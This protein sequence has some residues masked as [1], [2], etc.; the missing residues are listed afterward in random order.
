MEKVGFNYK[1]AM[2]ITFLMVISFS[3]IGPS[4]SSPTILKVEGPT[5]VDINTENTFN[6]SIIAENVKGLYGWELILT[7]SP[8]IVNC[9]SET[10]NYNIWGANNFLGPL[11][12]SPINNE[13]GTYWQG[14]TGKN[15]GVPQDGNFWLV[16]LTFQIVSSTTAPIM[17]TIKKAPGYD[18][19]CLLD[20]NGQEIP[21]QYQQYLIEIVPEF[22]EFFPLIFLFLT[23]SLVLITRKLMLKVLKV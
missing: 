5:E 14:L 17:F 6:I 22:S 16:N 12:T 18:N 15:P 7:W 10:L 1:Y 21:H 2:L 11:V 3:A 13:N 8:K 23:T 4:Y 9:T 20:I 19:Y